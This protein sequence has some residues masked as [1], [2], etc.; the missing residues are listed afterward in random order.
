MGK[1]SRTKRG[2][3]RLTQL[4]QQDAADYQA[5][6]AQDSFVAG[7][8][9]AAENAARKA[10]RS[11]PG[12]FKSTVILIDLLNG[13]ERGHE[14]PR[15]AQE[16]ARENPKQ[17]LLHLIA[18]N[19]AVGLERWEEA[20]RAL[21]KFDDLAK[22]FPG[23]LG[24]A[25]TRVQRQARQLRRFLKRIASHQAKE[26]AGTAASDAASPAP[27]AQDKARAAAR[28]E[29]AR[30]ERKT[31]RAAPRE[32]PGAGLGK[33]D[34]ESATPKP[35]LATAERGAGVQG[36]AAAAPR[37]LLQ[38]DDRAARKDA[39]WLQ[40]AWS[41][42]LAERDILIEAQRI[43]LLSHYEDLLC[44][45]TLRGVEQLEYQV[46]TARKILRRLNGRALLSDEV[47]LGKTIEA[48]MVIKEYLMRG[49]VR[50][51]LVLV[52]PGLVQQWQ[53]EM[54]E[55]FGL[56]F[57]LWNE[58]QRSAR[59]GGGAQRVRDSVPHIEASSEDRAAARAPGPRQAPVLAIDS[60][61][62]ARLQR[63]IGL[64]SDVDWDLVVV[65]EA[66]HV[67]R[68]GTRSW[69]LVNSLRKRYVLLL[70]ATPVHNNLMELHELVTL[71]RPGL[72][73]TAT[74]F[75][76]R[77]VRGKEGRRVRDPEKLREVLGEVMVRN[78]RSHA[79][80]ELPK[81]FASTFVLEPQTHEATAYRAASTYARLVYPSAKTA[82]RLWLRH[83]LGCAGS[84]PRALADAAGRRLAGRDADAATGHPPGAPLPE[85]ASS[86]RNLAAEQLTFAGLGNVEPDQRAP[87]G[88]G[89]L[90]EG[91]VAPA[92]SAHDD[93]EEAGR[94]L[95]QRI[96][97]EAAHVGDS[98]K[99]RRLL[100][101]VARSD[102][103]MV[104]FC[105][106]RTTIGE[107]SRRL[108][109]SRI[110]HAVYHGSL[111]R[112]E[113]DQVIEAFR[114][115]AR[116]LLSTESG[117]EGRNIQFC[118]TIVNYD[119]PWDPMLI[120]Q[121][122][123]RVHRI[124][125]TRDVFVFNLV[126]AGTLEEELL[127]ILEDKI[128][129]FELIVGEVDS[130]LGNLNRRDDFANIILDLWAGARDENDRRARF[131][132]FGAELAASRLAYEK[133]KELDE[134]LFADDLEV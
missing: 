49:L 131:D 95:L 46:E 33:R 109:E 76:R 54:A 119:L 88:S 81:R 59:A 39:G 101:L 60:I 117:G 77:F 128:H 28:I 16:A 132:A 24:R 105:R 31:A 116:V 26:R 96:V 66:H 6:L 99:T 85:I 47:G 27:A 8:W 4:H 73:G 38:V 2:R 63:N 35:S 11:C 93:V 124:G 83:L 75:R 80:V 74:E 61:A 36:E 48:G 53:E 45:P 13:S 130:I 79:D 102:E 100:E 125:Q 17:P 134:S 7:D 89:A 107:L 1:R 111:A 78:T 121:R 20:G 106:Q 113:K 118:R 22:R 72:L 10:L 55:K 15:L 14:V 126:V 123:G 103:Q 129:L 122:I 84:G 40:G 86:R 65:D 64:F 91:D 87:T 110:S 30:E 104:V 43:T 114:A 68:R 19:A 29:R 98:S 21:D 127:R 52:P 112:H 82:L 56:E 120:E 57:V 58:A 97:Q 12:H 51:V 5:F 67:R 108:T 50:K 133:E 94:R 70:S 25:R 41:D 69:T 44:L 34:A 37:I 71:V 23:Q 90:T 115:G 9:E 18:A 32:V 92:P 62:L 3:A 42:D